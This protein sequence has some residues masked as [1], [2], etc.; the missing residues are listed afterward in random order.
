PTVIMARTDANAAD[1]LTSDVD[2]YDKPFLTGER[3]VVGFY[4]TKAGLDQAFARG[5]AYAPYADLIWCETAEQDLQEAKDF[6]EAIHAE[7]PDQLLAYNCSPSFI[8]ERHMTE[9]EMDEF[10]KEIAK[11]G[12]KFQ[13]VTLA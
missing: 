9:A 8:W 3:T 11:M 5:L 10:Q 7:Y 2:E 4:R 12:Y 1:I 13:F 6:A